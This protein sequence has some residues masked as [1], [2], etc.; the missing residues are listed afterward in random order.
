MPKLFPNPRRSSVRKMRST[1]LASCCFCAAGASHRWLFAGVELFPHGSQLVK[2]LEKLFKA[3]PI[4]RIR[5][6]RG[7]VGRLGGPSFGEAAARLELGFV[8]QPFF[9]LAQNFEGGA[10]GGP[11]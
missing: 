10:L 3:A 4:L 5:D 11:A 1:A 6:K 7:D 9:E 8:L 2:M